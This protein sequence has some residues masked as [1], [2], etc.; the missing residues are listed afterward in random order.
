MKN[1]MED[2]VLEVLEE[3]LE[4]NPE[5][6]RC[7]KCKQDVVLLALSKIK[8]SYVSSPVGEIFARVGQSDRQVRTDA[9]LAVM[10]ALEQVA[11]NPRHDGRSNL[12]EKR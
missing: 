7:E 3:A 12:T 10:Q 1:F 6:C 2:V 9:L 11:A 5:F 8:G 4:T